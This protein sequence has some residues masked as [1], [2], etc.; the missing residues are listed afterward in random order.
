MNDFSRPT[1]TIIDPKAVL[2]VDKDR[3]QKFVDRLKGKARVKVSNVPSGAMFTI[4]NE[5]TAEIS[6]VMRHGDRWMMFGS[7]QPTELSNIDLEY[8]ITEELEI[9]LAKSK[10]LR[11]QDENGCLEWLPK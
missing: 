1:L 10:S 5:A 8:Y 6:T 11:I 4:C 9:A 2:E 7:G 3:K